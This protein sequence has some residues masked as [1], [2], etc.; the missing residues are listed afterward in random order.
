MAT[1][2][3]RENG[4]ENAAFTKE[5][6]E[7][8]QEE[9]AGKASPASSR[10]SA[11]SAGKRSAVDGGRAGSPCDGPA[12]PQSAA[13]RAVA[14][15]PPPPSSSCPG[16][17]DDVN[18][19]AGGHEEAKYD[20]LDA[21]EMGDE[22]PREKGP[23]AGMPKEV[24][25]QY[26]NKKR[27]RVTRDV[28]FWLIVVATVVL[29]AATVA[30]IALS[31]RCLDWWQA[32]PVY[33]IYPRSFRD[34]DG[35]GVGDLKGIKEKLDHLKYLNIKA[36][37]ISSFYTSP[38]VE[39]GQDVSD[40]LGVDPLL[41]SMNDVEDLITAIH[42]QDMKLIL[43]YIPNHTS[44]QHGWFNKSRNRE[45]TY[46]DYYI[47]R[48][49]TKGTP[50][51]NW[52]SVFGGPA[53]TFDDV[54][55]QCYFHQFLPQE[56]DLNL[57]NADVQKDLE[58]VLRFWLKKGVDGFIVDNV[59]WLL[60]ADHLRNEVQVNLAQ[61]PS[62]IEHYEELHHDFTT[63]Q[64]GLHDMVRNWRAILDEYSNEP[65]KYRFLATKSFDE[66]E[67][68][69]TLSYYGSKLQDE[70]DFPLN[71]QLVSLPHGASGSRARN[72]IET[73]MKGMIPSKW[74]NWMVGNQDIGRIASR[75]EPK[76]ARAFTM[77]LLTLPGTPVTYYGE[78]IGMTN[79]VVNDVQDP[80]GKKYPARNRDPQRSPMHWDNSTGAGFS[81]SSTTWLPVN[82]NFTSNVQAQKSDESSMLRLYQTL[83]QMRSSELPLHRGW[84]CFL[85]GAAADVL[86][87]SR[88]MD[89]VRTTYV[90]AINLGAVDQTVDLQ[91][92]LTGRPKEG[93]V[94]VSTDATRPRAKVSLAGVLVKSG[95]GLLLR[96][97][98][99]TP[100]HL[101]E[102]KKG[103]CYISQRACY[104]QPLD[105]LYK[106]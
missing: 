5:E 41:G 46:A 4:V 45:G 66:G 13:V 49:C 6:E 35:N 14:A 62:T 85:S 44:D 28:I 92:M 26:S 54:R 65:G 106:C 101:D 59:K 29:V 102:E 95:E 32:S 93:Y 63:T 75:L 34:A 16:K 74:P 55:D 43:D 10:S 71:F 91:Q 100:V 84:A 82:T 80:Y 23:Y 70:A 88:E 69:K 2:S 11:S 40:F 83:S 42:D 76:Y 90:V 20:N 57:R 52:V 87:F 9:L 72:L 77:L 68:E 98:T 81:N 99:G 94:S 73:W 1:D 61:D 15:G 79:V 18:S 48:N 103:S 17:D 51:N 97:D 56:P 37:L 33:Q 50:P 25:L 36:V 78:E 24:L 104:L 64:P 105:I 7:G 19:T 27:Y 12:A 47:W 39:Q 86:A 3:A 96:Y 30:V 60:E 8:E 67:I 22:V 89:G 21:M 53:W 38:Q 58:E 31:P